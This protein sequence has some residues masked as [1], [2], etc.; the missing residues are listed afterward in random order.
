MFKKII[1]V[2]AAVLIMFSS[3]ALAKGKYSIKTMTPEIKAAF[4][5][6][7]E[8]FADLRALK[9]SGAVGENNHGYVE[10]LKNEGQSSSITDEEN[11]DRKV[12][13]ITIAQ[14]NG[15]EGSLSTIES[16]FADVQREK[17]ETGDKV[18]NEDGGWI[19]K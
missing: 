19:S 16:A 2:I 6:R 7:K 4:H 5:A 9:A 12:I 14:Q 10:V 13:Y 11:R 3:L 17:A 1:I 8:R 15:L 18:Q